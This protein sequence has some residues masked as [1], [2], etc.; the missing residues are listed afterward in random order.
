[1]FLTASEFCCMPKTPPLD[2]SFLRCRWKSRTLVKFVFWSFC[3]FS[4]KKFRFKILGR[5]TAFLDSPSNWRTLGPHHGCFRTSF[6]TTEHFFMSFFICWFSWT[7]ESNK[8][9][10][11]V[12]FTWV[13]P[14]TT[15][16]SYSLSL[17]KPEINHRDYNHFF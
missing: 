5:I 1:M 13:D 12:S 6:T 9:K 8:L 16:T 14:G 10:T 15:S 4:F 11:S 2:I 17:V 7:L 3:K